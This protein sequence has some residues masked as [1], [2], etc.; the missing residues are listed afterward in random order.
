MN[1]SATQSNLISVF[2]KNPSRCCFL[3]CLPSSP[4]CSNNIICHDIPLFS[5]GDDNKQFIP[6]CQLIILRF[7]LNSRLPS[8]H[9]WSKGSCRQAS[10][11]T[12]QILNDTYPRVVTIV[13]SI[14]LCYFTC[15]NGKIHTTLRHCR[16][17]TLLWEDI[18]IGARSLSY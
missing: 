4:H 2:R 18:Y 13:I 17:T 11:L 1:Q 5:E 14:R 10:H 6:V 3:S 15:F 9:A 8:H 7:S 12:F 16:R